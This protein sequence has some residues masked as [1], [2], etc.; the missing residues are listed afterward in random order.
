[1]AN[2]WDVAKG[3]AEKH[4][5][6]GGIFVRLA[7]NGDKVTGV[8]CGEPYAREVVWTG[9]RYE[10]YD[11]KNPA[12]QGE[13]KRASLRVAI[14]FFA[15][16]EGAMKVI[17]GGSQWFKDVLKV[18]DKYGLDKWSFEIERHGE[19]GDPKTKYTIL[20][21]EKISDE[22]RKKIAG[23]SLHDLPNL[24]GSEGAGDAAPATTAPKDGPIDAA[25]GTALV[26]RL[27]ALPRAA[28]DGVLGELGVQRVRDMTMAQ[29]ARANAMLDQLAANAAE[30]DPFA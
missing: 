4:A 14:N 20:P 19:A 23:A 10:A 2:A 7:N 9:E 17:E 18:R 25:T 22:L 5:Q 11:A 24:S 3:L 6:A 26:A 8:F 29:A 12:H 27:K 15:I 21:E 1:M 13:G 30:V 16:A 28:V